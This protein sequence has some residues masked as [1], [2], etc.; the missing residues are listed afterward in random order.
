MRMTSL[1]THRPYLTGE[2]GGCGAS[3]PHS[4]RTRREAS[5]AWNN[6]AWAAIKTV[7]AIGV[8]YPDAQ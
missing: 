7:R 4:F 3:G 6:R 1:V 2:G 8:I 5:Q